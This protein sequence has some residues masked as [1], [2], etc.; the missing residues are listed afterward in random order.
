MP[1][2]SASTSTP[3]AEGLGYNPLRLISR[4]QV[5]IL[6]DLDEPEDHSWIELSAHILLK[7]SYLLLYA[8]C[9]SVGPV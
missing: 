7:L 1:L 9:T 5:A 4:Q 6:Q 3:G 8:K 2:L